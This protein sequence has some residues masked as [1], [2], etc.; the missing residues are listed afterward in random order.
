M[1]SKQAEEL[2][3]LY[4][5][6]TEAIAANPSMTLDEWRDLIEHWAEATAE[7]GG[8][9]YLETN[10]GGVPAMWVAELLSRTSA[11]MPYFAKRELKD[12]SA[13]FWGR[14]VIVRTRMPVRFAPTCRICR[15]SSSRQVETN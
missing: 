8:V 6:W 7:P 11:R 2:K 5:R 3:H 14:T 13:C 4:Q 15:R 1:A 12:S 10:A 9:D